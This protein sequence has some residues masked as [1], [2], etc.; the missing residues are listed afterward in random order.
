M[1]L[2]FFNFSQG[3]DGFDVFLKK[4]IYPLMS[5][6]KLIVEYEKGQIDAYFQIGKNIKQISAILDRSMTAIR[7]YP[8]LKN[9][10]KI[11][12]KKGRKRALSFRTVKKIQSMGSD[13]AITI[14]KIKADLNLPVSKSNVLRSDKEN[15]NLI[16]KKR[17]RNRI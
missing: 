17:D 1:N 6:G 2:N 7:N 13:K 16:Y 5:K 9:A 12:S 15:N 3:H 4:I 8:T 14:S 11:T 10:N